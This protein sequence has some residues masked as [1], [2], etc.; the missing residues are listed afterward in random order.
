MDLASY[1]RRIGYDAAPA[2]DFDT[3]LQLQRAHLAHIPYENLDVQLGRQL[4]LDP[5]DAFA[6]LVTHGRGGWCYEMNGLFAWVLEAIGFRI[7]PMTGAV[8][9]S[10]RGASAIGNHLVLAVDLD[11]PYLVDVGLGDGPSEPIPLRSGIY[12]QSWR[13]VRLEQL[14]EGWWRFHNV[15]TA[16]APSFDFQHRPADW[17]VLQQRCHWQQTSPDSRFVQNAICLRHTPSSI[18]ALVGRVLKT[19]DEHETTDQ[20][21]GSANSYAETLR[22]VFGISLPEAASLWPR[23]ARRHDD[24]FG[25]E[26]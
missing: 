11:Q 16:L 20:L 9:R 3:L 19:I 4:T 8:M 5:K 2:A 10:E 17:A 24:L 25:P 7:M 21:I 14:A 6:K 18:I 26:L 22:T 13:T 23:I 15:E 12:R 1:L